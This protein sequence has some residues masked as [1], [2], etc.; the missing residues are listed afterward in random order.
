MARNGVRGHHRDLPNRWGWNGTQVD[1]RPSGFSIGVIRQL[2]RQMADTAVATQFRVIPQETH[3]G[4]R[5]GDDEWQ[6]RRFYLLFNTRSVIARY[7]RGRTQRSCA[8]GMGLRVSSC[9]PG[10][11][12][13]SMSLRD[14]RSWSTA[15]ASSAEHTSNSRTT[16]TPSACSAWSFS[17]QPRLTSESQT[18]RSCS[19]DT[20]LGL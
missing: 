20:D 6:H 7:T 5:H 15:I 4:E 12:V 2:C 8:T 18:C 14:L 19:G 16:R 13:T 17:S 10:V 11:M 1:F 9:P 3:D